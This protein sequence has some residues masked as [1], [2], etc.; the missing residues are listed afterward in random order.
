MPLRS[1]VTHRWDKAAPNSG[2]RP[3]HRC[4]L[5]AWSHGDMHLLQKQHHTEAC[6]RVSRGWRHVHHS[7]RQPLEWQ[8]CFWA[9]Y[10][11]LPINLPLLWALWSLFDGTRGSRAVEGGGVLV[12][13]LPQ[14]FNKLLGFY[15]LYTIE[16]LNVKLRICLEVS[17]G[18]TANQRVRHH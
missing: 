8:D 17:Q 15:S 1:E 3:Q 14:E 9:A 7:P 4:H 10:L 16:V 13:V 5:H 12:L 2:S 18:F 11:H 6:R